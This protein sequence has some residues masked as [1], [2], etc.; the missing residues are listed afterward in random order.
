MRKQANPNY[1]TRRG[2]H[3]AWLPPWAE[4]DMVVAGGGEPMADGDRRIETSE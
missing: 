2:G 4:V 3:R 1:T